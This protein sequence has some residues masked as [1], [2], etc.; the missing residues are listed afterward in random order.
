M[1]NLFLNNIILAIVCK[2]CLLGHFE[3]VS[4]I[5]LTFNANFTTFSYFIENFYIS[6]NKK[7]YSFLE[8]KKKYIPRY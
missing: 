2:L 5:Q 1:I 7:T 4:I 8:I 6:F 3:Y